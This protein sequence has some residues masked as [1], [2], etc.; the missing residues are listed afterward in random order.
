MRVAGI[1]FRGAAGLASL[2]DALQRA[3]DAAGGGT[4]DALVSEA[5]KS[6]EPAF[7]ELAQLLHLPG[8]GVT[9][10]D[11]EQMITPTQSQRI[12]DRF[13]TGSLA[14]AAALAAAGPKAQLVV[15]RVISGD[16][17]ATAAIAES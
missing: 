14:E 5:A 17:M 12:Q 11:L 2:Q 3:L 16:G 13:G 6:R 9:Q 10:S 4:L 7:R 15:Q 1:G 8:L